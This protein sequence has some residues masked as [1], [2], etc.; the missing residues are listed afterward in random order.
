MDFFVLVQG[1]GKHLVLAVVVGVHEGGEGHAWFRV[2]VGV[3]VLANVKVLWVMLVVAYEVDE[4]VSV[5][6]SISIIL[7]DS[8]QE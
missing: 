3:E 6:V 7:S 4:V 2:R 1:W 5:T 8:L